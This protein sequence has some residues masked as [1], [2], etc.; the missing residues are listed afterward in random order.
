MTSGSE[1]LAKL[2]EPARVRPEAPLEAR[3]GRPVCSANVRLAGGSFGGPL[4]PRRSTGK[5]PGVGERARQRVSTWGAEAQSRGQAPCPGRGLRS[6]LRDPYPALRSAGGVS[7]PVSAL[8]DGAGAIHDLRHSEPWGSPWGRTTST[9]RSSD[10][11]SGALAW[12]RGAC[13]RCARS[14]GR[15]SASRQGPRVCP[16][17]RGSELLGQAGNSDAKETAA[18]TALAAVLL[19]N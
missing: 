12:T 18:N 6:L 9:G 14:R 8:G 4:G 17:A 19:I 1:Q 13:T 15:A 2:E 10:D 7:T 16:N 5:A 3:S 11:R